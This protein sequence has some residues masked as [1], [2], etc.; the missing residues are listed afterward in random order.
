MENSFFVG[1]GDRRREVSYDV[2]TLQLS[3]MDLDGLPAELSRCARLRILI[4][5][6][7]NIPFLGVVQTKNGPQ[8]VRLPDSLRVLRVVRCKVKRVGQLPAGLRELNVSYGYL[9]HLPALP[10][11]L[12]ELRVNNNRLLRLRGLPAGLQ[13]LYASC[14]RIRRVELPPGLVSANLG[15]NR[16]RSLDGMPASIRSLHAAGNPLDRLGALPAELEELCL[17]GTLGSAAEG[18]L[19]LVDAELPRNLQHLVCSPDPQEEE[20]VIQINT[21]RRLKRFRDRDTAVM[22]LTC[23][24]L[25]NA[26]LSR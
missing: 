26:Q 7:G 22:L 5:Y 24:P 18:G 20:L 15:T 10:P 11:A 21:G 6:E 19:P 3:M 16:L 12:Q 14:N 23:C 9:Q 1:A 13:R 8:G 4:V 25:V 17:F 2:E